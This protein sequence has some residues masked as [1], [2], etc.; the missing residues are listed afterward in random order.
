MLTGASLKTR[1]QL[2]EHYRGLNLNIQ[3]DNPVKQGNKLFYQVKC[4]LCGN[5]SVRRIDQLQKLNSWRC[6]G[7]RNTETENKVEKLG[8]EF[9]GF[10]HSKVSLKCVNC[11]AIRTAQVGHVNIGN[12]MC[13]SCLTIKYVNKLR[14]GGC[15]YVRRQT[16]GSNNITYVY[17]TNPEGVLCK[18]QSGHLMIDDWLYSPF[19][20]E[21]E[22]VEKVYV[23]KFSF[24]IENGDNTI[25]CGYY[26]KIG[27]SARPAIR[28]RKL[29]IDYPVEIEVLAEFGNYADAITHEKVLHREN[30][31]RQVNP[32]TVAMFTHG[33]VNDVYPD[34][35]TEWF[36][37]QKE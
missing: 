14:E 4:S 18:V 32:E 9:L 36:F 16:E 24:S 26:Y 30:K 21:R 6:T 15:E 22:K 1:E 19:D 28:S 3:W 31:A 29:K 11:G 7:C 37:K 33:K 8:F 10:V 12:V 20:K 25:P 13:R 23:Y 2:S 5:C 34:G 17:F 35:Y 27:V